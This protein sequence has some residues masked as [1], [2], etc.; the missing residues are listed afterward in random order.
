LGA[1]LLLTA[2]PWK[3][4]FSLIC[5]VFL[6]GL[7]VLAMARLLPYCWN[8]TI[9]V[10]SAHSMYTLEEAKPYLCNSLLYH[11][12]ELVILS[13]GVAALILKKIT[14]SR[15]E[16]FWAALAVLWA[17]VNCLGGFKVG[18]NEGNFDSALAPLL[19]FTALFL[20]AGCRV[21][22]DRCLARGTADFQRF[23][24]YARLLIIVVLGCG[25]LLWG[26][27]QGARKMT[28]LQA[29][30]LLYQTRNQHNAQLREWLLKNFTGKNIAMDN[31]IYADVAAVREKV[32]FPVCVSTLWAYRLG[33]YITAEQTR[34]II[35]KRHIALCF[36]TSVITPENF[37]EIFPDTEPFSPFPAGHTLARM[38]VHKNLRDKL[39]KPQAKEKSH[40]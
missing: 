38:L 26:K 21:I 11:S 20:L 33:N 12:G 1:F 23:P 4:K 39:T 17:G 2:I 9:T 29:D 32:N 30:Y 7:G 14:F 5:P 6:A 8:S 34:E 3:R 16:W 18:S 28:Q 35:R 22:Y 15:R 19:P 36:S 13:L 10:L 25:L 24:V 40:E 37:P 31:M 27:W